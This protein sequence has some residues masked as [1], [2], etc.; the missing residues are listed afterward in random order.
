MTL[1]L[2]GLVSLCGVLLIRKGLHQP[3]PVL[4]EEAWSNGQ[5]EAQ[6][7]VED[8]EEEMTHEIIEE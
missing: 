3:K 2:C 6:A 8:I 4:Q 5:P 1:A 7:V